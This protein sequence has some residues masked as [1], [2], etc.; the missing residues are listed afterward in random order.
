MKRTFNLKG[1]VSKSAFVL[2]VL[3]IS[4]FMISCDTDQKKVEGEPSKLVDMDK[5]EDQDNDVK[6]DPEEVEEDLVEYI[7]ENPLITY[8][9]EDGLYYAYILEGQN[10]EVS[11]MHQGHVDDFNNPRISPDGNFIVYTFQDDLYGYNL[12]VKDYGLIVENVVSYAYFDEQTLIY[13]AENKGLTKFDLISGDAL[14]EADDNI[15]PE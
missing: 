4:I 6:E 8:T 12:E 1:I 7:V 15:Y 2:F 14:H 3:M 5:V 13:S 9:K 11:L 10:E